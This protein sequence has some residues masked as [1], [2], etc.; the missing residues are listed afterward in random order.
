MSTNKN[1]PLPIPERNLLPEI[2]VIGT[3]KFPEYLAEKSTYVF[4]LEHHA[5]YFDF[6]DSRWQRYQPQ[7]F[8]VVINGDSAQQAHEVEDSIL[9]NRIVVI[10]RVEYTEGHPIIHARSISI[11]ILGVPKKQYPD[12]FWS[13]D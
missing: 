9:R 1:L 5:E 11:D 7:R 10:G 8:E 4:F 6:E 13:L 2:T 3:A 12:N